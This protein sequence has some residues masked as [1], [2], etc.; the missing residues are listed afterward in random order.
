MFRIRDAT[1][2]EAPVL[3]ALQRRASAVWDEYR[4]Q[5][6]AGVDA[7]ATP[8]PAVVRALFEAG[9][10]AYAAGGALP[11]GGESKRTASSL[12]RST[13]APAA[14]ATRCSTPTL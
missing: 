4:V 9:S 5:L 2:T 11:I 1:D 6:A 7:N 12:R 8:D 10:I 14:P 13:I 3:E